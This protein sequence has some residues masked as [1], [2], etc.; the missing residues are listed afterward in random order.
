[1]KVRRFFY[2]R[3]RNGSVRHIQRT[4]WHGT[5]LLDC[6]RVSA[7]GWVWARASRHLGFIPVCKQCERARER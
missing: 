6:G 5:G 2:V 1:M 4:R 3:P 7:S